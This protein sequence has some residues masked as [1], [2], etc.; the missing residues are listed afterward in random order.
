M[1]SFPAGKLDKRIRFERRRPVDDG[2]GN[3][4]DEWEPLFQRFCNVKPVQGREQVEAGVL[5]STFR[6][7]VKVR[8][9]SGTKAVTAADRIVFETPPYS[10]LAANIRSIIPQPDNAFIDLVVEQGVAD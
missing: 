2:Y 6:A 1:R 4:R 9:D 8:R 3:V 10:G 7:V 5:E